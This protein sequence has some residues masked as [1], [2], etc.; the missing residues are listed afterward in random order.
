MRQLTSA[1]EY[2][3]LSSI[4]H[5]DLKIENVLIDKTG[6][7]KLIDF[8]LCNYYSEDKQLNTFCGSLYFAAPELLNAKAYTGPEIDIWSL[9]V[10]MFVLVS[11]RVPFDDVSMQVLHQKIKAGQVEY[12]AYL[13]PECKHLISRMLVT[14]PAERATM[15]EV[16]QHTWMV[17]G[18]DCPPPNF[19]PKRVP[20]L[21]PLNPTIISFMRA[22]E[23]GTE[24]E[25]VAQ[26]EREVMR[27]YAKAIIT[28]Q[29]LLGSPV[30][31]IYYL[32]QEK[33]INDTSMGA[34]AITG[35]GSMVHRGSAVPG[36]TA[37]DTSKRYTS[38]FAD[39]APISPATMPSARSYMVERTGGLRS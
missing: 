39:Q 13:T 24:D 28:N 23:F 31:S 20:P 1:V 2:C 7:I 8:G 37:I 6:N 29:I 30:L 19:V 25:I 18:F 27:Q 4:V 33:L 11:G 9:G 32:I 16:K 38:S 36:L 15:D 35:G 21:I 5:R 3:H 26:L 22:F 34:H 17:K 14:N 12:P 10:I